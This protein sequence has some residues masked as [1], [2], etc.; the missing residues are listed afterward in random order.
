MRDDTHPAKKRV[1]ADVCSTFDR[2]WHMVCHSGFLY[3]HPQAGVPRYANDK[4]PGM[5]A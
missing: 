3:A 4:R 1:R 5:T 2:H